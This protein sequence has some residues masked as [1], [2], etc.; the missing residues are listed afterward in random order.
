MSFRDSNEAAFRRLVRAAIRKSEMTRGEQAV[1][2]V[3]ANL[4]FHH[5]NGPEGVI[6]PGRERIGRAAGVSIK[7]VTRTLAKLRSAGCLIA[8]SHDKGG[9]A[10]T[11]YRLRLLPLLVL[12]GAN[13]P[14]WVDGELA[15]MRAG[16]V[17]LSEAEMSRFT[18]DKMSHGISTVAKRHS[19]TSQSEVAASLR[20][21]GGRDV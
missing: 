18:R 10:A 4:W 12:C 8:V 3:L 15:P 19:R 14:S 21:V 20:V 6:R 5:R 17:P 7:T 9:R 13:L 2:L 16:N 11:R 1:T